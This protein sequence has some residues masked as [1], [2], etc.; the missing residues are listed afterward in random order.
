MTYCITNHYLIFHFHFDS[1]II[2][3]AFKSRRANLYLARGTMESACAH[4]VS[5]VVCGTRWMEWKITCVFM[6]ILRQNETMHES[7]HLQI[8]AGSFKCWNNRNHFPGKIWIGVKRVMWT[9]NT[10]PTRANSVFIE[11]QWNHF[12]P[13]LN[14]QPASSRVDDGTV[15][16]N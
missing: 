1:M 6:C 13:S 11:I 4:S 12:F 15:D 9:L 10:E 5:I 7:A 16:C 2:A 3:I 8:G 14:T